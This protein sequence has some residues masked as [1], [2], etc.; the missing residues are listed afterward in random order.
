MTDIQ[1]TEYVLG[2]AFD[3]PYGVPE[4]LETE[5]PWV[6]KLNGIGGKM[7]LNETPE[8]AM[9]REFR[10]ETGVA[11]LP[12][13]W[14]PVG[15]FGNEQY[16]VYVF[17]VLQ[18]RLIELVLTMTDEPLERVRTSWLGEKP[19]ASEGVLDNVKWLAPMAWNRAIGRTSTYHIIQEVI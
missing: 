14:L 9:S 5:S 19:L 15:H 13:R 7:E 18:A 4:G 11:I 2:F 17:T 12:E 16:R 3:Y 1:M 8:G 6:V 10:E